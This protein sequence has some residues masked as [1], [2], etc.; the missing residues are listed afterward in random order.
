MDG[1][2]YTKD[3]KRLIKVPCQKT[4][5]YIVP[6]GVEEIE[7]TAFQYSHLDEVILPESLKEIGSLCFQY[8]ELKKVTIPKSLSELKDD[9]FCDCRELE[10]FSFLG[11]TSIQYGYVDMDSEME[12]RISKEGLYSQRNA[13]CLPA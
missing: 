7:V 4:G 8:S 12:Q 9:V 3:G 5:T 11:D 1:A 13:I 6:E 10:E 2:L